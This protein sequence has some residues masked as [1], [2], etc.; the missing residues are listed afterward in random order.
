VSLRRLV[1]LLFILACSGSAARGEPQ[2]PGGFEGAKWIW[3]ASRPEV[4]LRD[5]PAGTA[6][7]RAAVTVPEQSLIKTAE[8]SVT[9]DNLY[10]FYLNGKAAGEGYTNPNDWSKPK[11]FDVA[12]FLLPGIT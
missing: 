10:T 1:C 3:Y 4:P 5:L 12:G 8:L 11:R 9:A 2:P 7:F 6:F